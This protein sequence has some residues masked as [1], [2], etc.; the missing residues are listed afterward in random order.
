MH[1]FPLGF[2]FQMKHKFPQKYPIRTKISLIGGKQ[3]QDL[4]EVD[5]H[6]N[7]KCLRILYLPQTNYFICNS[8]IIF[9]NWTV[10]WTRSYEVI[11]FTFSFF[12]TQDIATFYHFFA[13]KKHRTV[14]FPFYLQASVCWSI[15]CRI[16]YSLFFKFFL[17]YF[18]R[19]SVKLYLFRILYL[20][21]ESWGVLQCVQI[22][23]V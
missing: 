16:C 4:P 2:W 22:W 18:F 19:P 11:V 21:L 13:L 9:I 17:F 14:H 10:Q 6:Q 8:R 3:A 20:S 12:S 5:N 1:L 7:C 15:W 23:W